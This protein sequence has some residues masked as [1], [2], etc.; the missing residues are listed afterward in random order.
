ME[1]SRLQLY[2]CVVVM[3]VMVVVTFRLTLHKSNGFGRV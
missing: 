1:G 2:E 3:V